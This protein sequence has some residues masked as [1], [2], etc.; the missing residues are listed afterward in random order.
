MATRTTKKTFETAAD[1]TETVAAHAEATNAA[2]IQQY[3]KAV[4]ATRDQVAKASALL[5]DLAVLGKDNLDAVVQS[6]TVIA[7]GLE[8]MSREV[9]TYAQASLESAASVTKAL[10]SAKTLQDVIALNNDFAKTQLDS[11]LA[12]STKL[13]DLG[14]KVATEALEPISKRVNVTIEKLAKPAL[15]A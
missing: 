5:E 7:K 1:A 15:A 10:F 11:F 4:A 2:A 12:N 6:N 13:S 14:A 3:E 8:Q 9:M